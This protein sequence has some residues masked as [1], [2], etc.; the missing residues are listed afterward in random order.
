MHYRYIITVMM[1]NE[2]SLGKGSESIHRRRLVPATLLSLVGGLA[3][4]ACSTQGSGEPT[5]ITPR[6]P[7][8]ESVGEN[9]WSDTELAKSNNRLLKSVEF[10]FDPSY[11][12][13]SLAMN[14][15]FNTA[16]GE[17]RITSRQLN[18]NP[19]YLYNRPFDITQPCQLFHPVTGV[20]PDEND[21]VN[22]GARTFDEPYDDTYT[23]EAYSVTRQGNTQDIDVKPLGRQTLDPN[24]I[25]PRDPSVAQYFKR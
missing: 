16:S 5:P 21:Q 24:S 2:Q 17:V 6:T 18:F 14:V 20:G 9:H 22:I 19:G 13:G 1:D 15:C 11:S 7:M 8:T 12:G 3:I 25:K 23:G 4:A 10:Y